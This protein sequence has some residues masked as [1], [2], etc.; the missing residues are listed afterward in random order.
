M[1]VK[2]VL[3]GVFHCLFKTVIEPENNNRAIYMRKNKTRLKYDAKCTIYTS[4]SYLRRE[5][6]V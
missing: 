4:M 3:L 5:Q 6:L 2:I 1:T